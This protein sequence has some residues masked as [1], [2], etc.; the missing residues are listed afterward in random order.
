MSE[1]IDTK[2]ADFIARGQRWR[3][4]LPTGRYAWPLYDWETPSLTPDA[5][6]TLVGHVIYWKRRNG[7]LSVFGRSVDPER[8]D[9]LLL[10]WKA[11][12]NCADGEY[13]LACIVADPGRYAGIW[14]Q[15]SGHCGFCGRAL[16]DQ[17]SREIGIGPECV[18]KLSDVS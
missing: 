5:K 17:H 13:D 16:T 10:H 15:H 14:G 6:P 12:E 8:R 3:E 7:K 18:K 2:Y 4:L 11:D 1:Y 9:G